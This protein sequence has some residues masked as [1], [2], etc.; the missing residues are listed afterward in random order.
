M[1]IVAALFIDDIQ[2][3]QVPGPSTRIDLTGVQ[4]SAA[5][6]QEAPLVWAPHLVVIVRCAPGE[7]GV[8]ALEVTYWRD[9]EQIARN[10]QPLQVEPGKFNYRLVRAELEFD[11]YGTVEARARID[12]GAVTVVPYTLLA[13]AAPEARDA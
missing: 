4:F 1:D 7:S 3:R 6:A 8:G 5:A 2:L 13:P 12:A 10:V 11:D 9:E